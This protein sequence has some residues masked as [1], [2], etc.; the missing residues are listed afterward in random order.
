M[1]F[2]LVTFLT[3]A[4][5]FVFMEFARG[6]QTYLK[7]RGKRIVSCPENHC[8]AAVSVAAGNAAFETIIGREQLRLNAC[9]RW[10]EKQECAQECLQQIEADPKA[11]LVWTIMNHSP[12]AKKFAYCHKPSTEV[13]WHDHQ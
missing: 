1:D 8:D 9:S 5:V 6:L 4:A 7:F 13:H 11:C 12:Q 3:F 2:I 10:P